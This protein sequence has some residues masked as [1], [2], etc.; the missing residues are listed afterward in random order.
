MSDARQ[1]RW[2][3]PEPQSALVVLVPEV[4]DSVGAVRSAYDPGAAAGIPAHITILYPF[5]S[6]DQLSAATIQQVGAC[7][8]RTA[9]FDYTLVRVERFFSVLYLAPEPSVL[10]RALTLSV[11]KEF[12]AF[13]P[14]SG[15][16]T[17]IVP[18]LTVAS[19]AD[20]EALD[21][22]SREFE[23][24]ARNF[25]PL[26]AR[27]KEVALLTNGTG[28]WQIEMTFSLGHA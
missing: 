1:P 21:Q 20:E 27:A 24:I 15:R 28:P 5:Q 14:Y 7:F 3:E 9:P 17:D 18:H 23:I 25:L 12:P 4:E 13:P 2:P 10:F 26:P 19:L 16:Y 8:R 6:P 11:W 22:L